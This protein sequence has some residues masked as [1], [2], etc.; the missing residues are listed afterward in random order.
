MRF[1][2]QKFARAVLR[3]LGVLLLYGVVLFPVT[4]KG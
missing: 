1:D 3:S 4:S 2:W